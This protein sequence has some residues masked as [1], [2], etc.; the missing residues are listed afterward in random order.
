MAIENIATVGMIQKISEGSSKSYFLLFLFCY[1]IG[2][3]KQKFD[4]LKKYAT[5]CSKIMNEHYMYS[6][7]QPCF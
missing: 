3:I 5:L 1:F 6:I 2:K 4:D 7:G